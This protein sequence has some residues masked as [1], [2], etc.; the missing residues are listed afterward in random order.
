MFEEIEESIVIVFI[1]IQRQSDPL[2]FSQ[3]D[4]GMD[5]GIAEYPKHFVA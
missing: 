3:A 5:L 1:P 4:D 2:I